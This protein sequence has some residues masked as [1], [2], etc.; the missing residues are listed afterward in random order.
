M[1]AVKIDFTRTSDAGPCEQ[2]ATFRRRFQYV[3]VTDGVETPID[4]TGYTARM[5]VRSNIDSAGTI[6]SLTTEN[7]GI[8]LGGEMGYIDIYISATATAGLPVTTT[9]GIN[10]KYPLYDLELVLGT[11]VTRFMEG[12]FAVIGEVTR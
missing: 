8:V 10:A 2:G 1:P 3:S 5:Q 4:L 6:L 12:K 11:E 9:T 7:G